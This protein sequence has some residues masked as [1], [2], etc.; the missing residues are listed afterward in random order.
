MLPKV[1]FICVPLG[2]SGDINPMV[3]LGRL[4]A[5]RGHDVVMVMQAAM[6]ESGR[7]AGLRTRETGTVEA[8]ETLVRNPDL[9]H[10]KRAFQV[11][12]RHFPIWA[13]EMMP[14]IRQEIVPGRTVLIGAGI[15]FAARIIAE[16]DAV[17]LVTAQLQPCV[18]MSPHDC[19]VLMRGMERLKRRPLWLRRLAFRL[20]RWETDR[21]LARQ[22]NAVR[23]DSG[24]S[25]P[26]RG[27]MAR[28]WFSPDMVLGLFP[29]WFGP[30]QP[31]WPPNVVLTRFPLNDEAAWRP[32]PA[33]LEAFLRAG[34]PPVLLTPGSANLHAREFFASGL[35]A[36][37]RLGR[38]ALL[39]TAFKEQLPSPL[40]P[41]AAHFEFLPFGS[42]FPRCAAVMHHGGIGTCAQ[43]MAAGVPQ[44]IMAMAY[45]QPDNG[46]RL[47]QVG[48]GNY[49][50]AKQFSPGRVANALRSLMDAPQVAAACRELQSRVRDQMPPSAVGVVL[51]EFAA[52]H[53]APESAGN[54]S[55][56]AQDRQRVI[57]S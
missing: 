9:W 48:A 25:Q 36:C 53:L 29:E 14:V 30:R 54:K 2:S 33:A 11:L 23:S 7:R 32:V 55:K 56:R 31:D 40:P 28:W 12:A 44:L 57:S 3:W 18:F 13:R 38:R 15:A 5:D 52:R 20:G 49:L 47:Q 35:N 46:W 37:A 16:A 21:I 42:V 10:P 17:P 27:I 34:S 50:Y 45:D 8:Q 26:V 43:A 41:D 4:L 22:I 6:A 1:R 19:P 39:V 51:E 24:L